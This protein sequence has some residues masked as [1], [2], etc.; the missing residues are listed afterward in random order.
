[1]SADLFDELLGLE[2]N[3][4]QEGYDAGLA[5]GEHAGVVEGKV[6]GVEK[7]YEKALEIGKLHGRALVWQA[8]Q[9][10]DGANQSLR[11]SSSNR[12]AIISRVCDS[13]LAKNS[14]LM[15]HIEALLLLTN[16][17]SIATN[18]SDP[19]V[20]EFDDRLARAQAKAKVVAAIIGEPLQVETAAVAVGGIE[21]SKDS[22]PK[23]AGKHFEGQNIYD[24]YFTTS[25]L[26][27][28]SFLRSANE[29]LHLAS[30]HRSAKY[31]CMFELNPLR[32][33]D[34][35]IV[36]LSYE[37][38]Q[39][40]IGEPYAKSER[41][42][43]E[44][45]DSTLTSPTLVFM[46]L[47]VEVPGVSLPTESSQSYTG[48]PYFALDCS[49]LREEELSML[50]STQTSFPPTRV[51]LSLSYQQSSLYAQARS[52]LD[53]AQRNIFCSACGS[54][55]LLV[56]GGTKIICPPKDA[57]HPH[58]PPR[59]CPTRTG[60]HN[61]A[62]PRTDPTLIAA[63]VSADGRRVLLG[64]GKRWAENYFSCLSGFVEPAE[65]M[66]S[67]TRREVWEESGVKVHNVQIH[68][69]QA[70]PYPSTLLVGT[71][72]QCNS[73][74]DEVISYPENE[75]GEARWFE[76]DEVKDALDQGHAMW[77]DPP[78]G[79]TGIRLPSDKLM[80]HRT[81]RGVIKL[82]GRRL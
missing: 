17:D 10:Q 58:R 6:F 43:I 36:L 78:K 62:Y 12:H 57:A 81:L 33:T 38:V 72:A 30:Q 7:G 51:D 34:G 71:I 21:E 16:G 56:Q 50:T 41:T 31:L 25:P 54:P 55:T 14:R 45:F 46:G 4:Y 26:S 63:A 28:L 39:S 9:N 74:E 49:N 42:R 35:Q 37:D 47:D 22:M 67:A 69:S 73:K 82:F 1:M 11:N 68:S 3:F 80:A 24:A 8:R 19:A 59:N 44:K 5:D 20:T 48:T 53:W 60:L 27:R 15:K 23:L 64:R 79:W 76:L 2:D 13:G 77:E 52:Y 65:S 75:L 61:T 40:L 18:N 29:L 66:E 70:W 32:G